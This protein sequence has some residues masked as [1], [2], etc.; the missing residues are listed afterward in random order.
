MK[1][2][3]QV[4]LTCSWVSLLLMDISLVP[5]FILGLDVANFETTVASGTLKSARPFWKI[6]MFVQ[7][8]KS[9]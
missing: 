1:F 2:F 8:F 7:Y 9:D 4:S 5:L 6:P 3:A